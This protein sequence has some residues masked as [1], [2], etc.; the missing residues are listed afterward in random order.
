MVPRSCAEDGKISK[1]KE[2]KKIWKDF[3]SVL[4]SKIRLNWEAFMLYAHCQKT[5]RKEDWISLKTSVSGYRTSSTR[6][7][8]ELINFLICALT[9]HILILGWQPLSTTTILILIAWYLTYECRL[10]LFQK[11][12]PCDN[13]RH[14]LLRVSSAAR[15]SCDHIVK[16]NHTIF[17]WMLEV[18]SNSINIALLWHM[19][20][21]DTVAMTTT[22]TTTIF[23]KWTLI[24]CRI[25]ET[26]GHFWD[27]YYWR[28][29]FFQL[30]NFRWKKQLKNGMSSGH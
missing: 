8:P 20:A 15:N 9:L 26:G 11:A 21:S 2:G 12:Q 29:H 22:S 24:N 16:M 13:M 6:N 30:N 3:R 18:D 4:S 17:V 25:S 5:L 1:R 19:S 7:E 14:I 27:I 28:A 10:F 23:E